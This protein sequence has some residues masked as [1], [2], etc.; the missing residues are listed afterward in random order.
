MNYW[1]AHKVG[2]KIWFATVFAFLRI[3]LQLLLWAQQYFQVVGSFLDSELLVEEALAFTL[4]CYM[5]AF[6]FA[7]VWE[8]AYE[9]I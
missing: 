9:I 1:R 4:I 6:Y 8:I 3:C 2:Y 7:T 5:F